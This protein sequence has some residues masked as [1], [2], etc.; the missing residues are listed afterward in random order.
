MP[1][2]STNDPVAPSPAATL[3]LEASELVEQA[4]RRASGAS[5]VDGNAVR[6]LKD[7]A[8]NYAA[9]FAAIRQPDLDANP[10]K[11]RT[12]RMPSAIMFTR[13]G[14]D[15]VACSRDGAKSYE[16]RRPPRGGRD[17]GGPALKR[18]YSSFEHIDHRVD[19]SRVASGLLK[20]KESL[21]AFRCV[22][23]R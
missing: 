17:G 13:D 4:Y 12:Q 18:C 3:L 22:E 7:G 5:R 9:W 6:I 23:Y 11:R 14:Y 19:R 21:A 16:T 10:R 8:A 20:L 2:L 1:E 15:V